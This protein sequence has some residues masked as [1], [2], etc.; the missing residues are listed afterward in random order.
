MKPIARP[1]SGPPSRTMTPELE[2][3]ILCDSACVME[4]LLSAISRPGCLAVRG[5]YELAMHLGRYVIRRS[6]VT[7]LTL[8]DG[9]LAKDVF[10]QATNQT[11]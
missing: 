4:P 7:V 8:E 9:E 6:G 2:S 10:R 1:T 11:K 5:E 3:K